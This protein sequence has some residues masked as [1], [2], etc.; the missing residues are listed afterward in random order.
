MKINTSPSVNTPKP[1][2]SMRR[3]QDG[4]PEG[5]YVCTNSKAGNN[6]WRAIVL[7]RGCNKAVLF[8]SLD[9]NI[10]EPWTIDRP[11]LIF[12]PTSETLNISLSHV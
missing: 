3:L 10:L 2:Y 8:L 1:C 12:E 11:D 6:W 9:H 4:A 7:T 5:I